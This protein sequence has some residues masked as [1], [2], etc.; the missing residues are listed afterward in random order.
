VEA[1]RRAWK[2]A[3]GKARRQR[4]GFGSEETMRR[5]FLRHLGASPQAYRERFAQSS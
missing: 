4:C 5:S 3:A 2:A 1:A